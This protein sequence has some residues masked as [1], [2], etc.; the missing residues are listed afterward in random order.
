MLSVLAQ[1][2]GSIPIMKKI[3]GLKNKKTPL[4]DVDGSQLL[5]S[6]RIQKTN[7]GD[8][9]MHSTQNERIIKSLLLP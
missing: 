5:A 1:Q 7:Q 9:T 3:R 6:E 8:C 4:Y 2:T